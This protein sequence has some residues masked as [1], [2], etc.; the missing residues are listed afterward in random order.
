MIEAKDIKKLSMNDLVAYYNANKALKE[1][2][3][4]TAQMN[5]CYKN[6]VEKN[7]FEEPLKKQIKCT[8]VE[9]K[10]MD[11]FEKRLINEE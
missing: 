10:I 2:Y 8:N 7:L 5:E 1:Y 6:T 9:S 11:E 4:N 3:A